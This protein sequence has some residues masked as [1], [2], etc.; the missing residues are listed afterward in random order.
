MNTGSPVFLPTG[1]RLADRVSEAAHLLGVATKTIY[2]NADAVPGGW[3]LRHMPPVMGGRPYA[4]VF[5]WTGQS[6]TGWKAAAALVGET[7]GNLKQRK[8]RRG[9]GWYVCPNV[10]KKK[11]PSL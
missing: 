4:R 5:L 8:I 9:D 7:P 1:E 11:R 2:R 6:A 3:K 10:W